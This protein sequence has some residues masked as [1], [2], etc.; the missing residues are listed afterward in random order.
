MRGWHPGVFLKSNERYVF[1]AVSLCVL[2]SCSG[3]DRAGEKPLAPKSQTWAEL[4]AVRGGV[5]VT[6]PGDAERAPYP[7]ERLVDAEVVHVAK[8]G[9]AWLRRDGG[10]TLLVRGPA[11]LTLRRDALE[12]AEG[13]VFIDSPS[14]ET[15]HVTTPQGAMHL[16]RVRASLDVS[17]DAARGTEAYVLGGEV[18]LD[19]H[20]AATSGERLSLVGTAGNVTS[21][22]HAALAWDDWTGGLA[23]TDRSAEPAPFGVGTVG[24]RKPGDLGAPRSPLAISRLDVRVT[25]DEDLATTEVDETFFNP[26]SDVVEGIYQFRTPDAAVLGRFGVDREGV[27]V[28]GRVKEKAAAAAQYASNVYEGSTE[29]PALLEWDAPGVYRAKLYP[30]GPGESRRVVVRYT[31][32]L[33][34]TGSKG[35]R[36]LYVYPMAAEGAEESLPR[37]EEL[38]ATF[39]L[40]KSHA[41][42]VRTGMGGSRSGFDVVVRAHDL[43]PRADLAVELFDEGIT[44]PRIYRA[45]H[46]VDTEVLPPSQ[47]A[48]AQNQSKGEVDYV[49]AAV[50]GTEVP[51]PA[52]GLDLVVVVDTSAATERASLA[53]AQSAVTALL[54]H[55]G[56]GDRAVVLA[57]D[58]SLR[59][60]VAGWSGLRA[61]D[62]TARRDAA[63][64]LARVERGGA[65]DLGA[66]LADAAKVIDPARQGAVVYIGDGRPTVGELSFTD[67]R[68]RLA[69]LPRP[70]RTFGLGIGVDADLAVLKGVSRGGFA[71]RIGDG[72]TAARAALRL[73]EA[74]GRPAWLGATVDLGPTVERIFPRQLGAL[75]D[76]E[77]QVVV[78]RLVGAT[79]STVTIT[80]ATGGRAVPVSIAV[81]DDHGDLRARWAE[82]RLAQMLDEGAGRAALVD[83]GSRYGI[84]TPHTSFYVPTTNEMSGE[85]RADVE[86]RRAEGRAVR[87]GDG[88]RAQPAEAAAAAGCGAPATVGCAKSESAARSSDESEAVAL[89]DKAGGTGAR[90]KGAEGSMGAPSPASPPM[91]VVQ[92][93]PAMDLA[94]RAATAGRAGNGIGHGAGASVDSLKTAPGAPAATANAADA[95]SFGMVGAGI[96]LSGIGEGGGGAGAGAG[97]DRDGAGAGLA[98][99]GGSSG[100]AKES[101]A[102]P[103]RR[104]SPSAPH[105]ADARKQKKMDLAGTVSAANVQLVVPPPVRVEVEV[106]ALPH[107]PLRCSGAAALPIDERV[108]LWRER[109]ASTRGDAAGTVRIYRTA[110]ARCEAPSF[111][112]RSRL[113]TRMLDAMPTVTGRVV[114]WRALRTDVDAAD[115]L[116]RGILGRVRTPAELR[117]LHT[118]LGLRNAEPSLVKKLLDAARSPEERAEKLRALTLEF[119]DDFELALHLLDALEDAHDANGARDLGRVLRAR[120]DADAHVRTSVGELYLRLAHAS[121]NPDDA[122]RDEA[123]AKRTFGEIVEFSPDDPVARRRLGDLLRAHAWFADA[124]RQYET[125]AHLTPDDTSV[126]LLRAAA[127]EGLGKLEEAVR[128]TEATASSGSPDSQGGLTRTARAFAATYLAWGRISA[129]EAAKPDELATLMARAARVAAS[130]RNGRKGARVVLTWAHPEMHPTLWS[131]ALGAMMPADGGDGTLGIAQVILPARPDAAI[132]ARI[133]PDELER[134]A[135][136]GADATLTVLFDEGQEG[137]RLVRIPIR[138]ARGG[139]TVQR[140]RV[141]NGEVAP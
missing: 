3:R 84:I 54:A 135:R 44:Q 36:R 74:A 108:A 50:R 138:F 32:W 51:R 133:E 29:D 41:R 107:T 66:M 87:S 40:E 59:P 112:E 130:D 123:E 13:R 1:V 114:L 52:G 42:D 85:E 95:P 121:T 22:K 128:W 30:I 17:R 19:G 103:A 16:V 97:G 56:E 137:E 79:P 105:A 73:L 33:A 131:N 9:L 69:K 8:D 78:G 60:V 100:G 116:Y 98:S 80:T 46:V 140:F 88:K 93:A 141:A 65:T 5:L 2:A 76:G 126:A 127:A 7:R 15:T 90:A 86:R 91:P 118:A 117:E 125:L 48:T 11:T 24:A 120:P 129:R 53:V 124:A 92:A 71:E 132:E 57:G 63:L 119:P 37:I 72:A 96:G 94:P 102:K 89:S 64:G 122:A 12:V 18:R 106:N 115:V 113:L 77:S 68:D 99:N 81:I 110:L 14:E 139:P 109:L 23:T 61:V 25:V 47:R 101:V 34:R 4:R 28:W 111:R 45:P 27:V 49:V 55:L 39:A 38:T 83:L 75:V 134:T 21:S 20:E 10:A 26:S 82:A 43:V 62:E 67:L 31:E 136:L 35:E 58:V 104:P 70:V 6:P